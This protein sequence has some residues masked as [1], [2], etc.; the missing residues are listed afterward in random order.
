MCGTAG[1]NSLGYFQYQM[2]HQHVSKSQQLRS[3]RYVGMFNIVSC[4]ET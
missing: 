4:D 3:R 1:G 2:F